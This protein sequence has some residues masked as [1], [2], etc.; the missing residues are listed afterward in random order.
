MHEVDYFG[1]ELVD[2]LEVH[3]TDYDNV[4]RQFTELYFEGFEHVE[5]FVH[6]TKTFICVCFSVDERKAPPFKIR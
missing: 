3:D 5:V 4:F 1:F 6:D 2:Q